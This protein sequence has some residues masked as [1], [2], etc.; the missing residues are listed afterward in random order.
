MTKETQ[1]VLETFPRLASMATRYNLPD[2]VLECFLDCA[3]SVGEREGI[4]MS[5]VAVQSIF[6]TKQ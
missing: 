3:Y 6:A 4:A 5:H 1:K 2:D